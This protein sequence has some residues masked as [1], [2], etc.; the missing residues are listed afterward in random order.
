[1]KK[2]QINNY[3]S[4]SDFWELGL[5]TPRSVKEQLESGADDDVLVE[6]NSGG[7][8]VFCA[9]EIVNSL[10][11]YE[12]DG[13]GSV[14]TRITGMAASAAATIFLAAKRRE[15]YELSYFMQHRAKTAIWGD[16]DDLGSE[17]EL[18]RQIDEITAADL[19]ALS[20]KSVKKISSLIS[21][22]WN[23][24]GGA[25]IVKQGIATAL[26]E[27]TAEPQHQPLEQNPEIQPQQLRAA[28]H[29]AL[30]YAEFIQPLFSRP[31]SSAK[32]TLKN[33]LFPPKNP[34]TQEDTDVTEAEHQAALKTQ[35]EQERK[36]ISEIVQVAQ[37]TTGFNEAAQQ[38]VDDG[39]P[40]AEFAKQI[41][42]SGAAK[43]VAPDEP[44][45]P[46]APAA[47]AA[48]AAQSVPPQNDPGVAAQ[49]GAAQSAAPPQIETAA[50]E[51]AK[52]REEIQSAEKSIL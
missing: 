20:G 17:A 39:T 52:L 49:A 50:Q 19:A 33:W 14:T 6:I 36:R 32:P 30:Q 11:Q 38:A 5:I 13:R 51:T 44:A 10:R 8:L 22:S 15:V 45:A 31:Q 42:L 16:Q 3:I 7:G 12:A 28:G 47:Q 18:L 29:D 27:G 34:T 43:P 41:C 46:A 4:D 9:Y 35:I 24:V 37:K 40:A 48:Q 21:S 23:L 25:Q 26:V 1:M 2:I